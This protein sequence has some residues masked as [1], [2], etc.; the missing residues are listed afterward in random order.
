MNNAELLSALIIPVAI[1]MAIIFVIH[2]IVSDRRK[3]KKLEG[4][5]E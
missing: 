5:N 3:R 1:C 4:K 2:D